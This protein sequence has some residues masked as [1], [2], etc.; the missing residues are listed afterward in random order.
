L[1]K[2]LSILDI[3]NSLN[4]SP[5]TVSFIVNGKAK[6]KRISDQLVEKVE[7]YIGEVGYTPNSLARSLR[8]GK[9]NIIGLMV[10]SISN[11]FFASIARLI[12]TKAYNNGYKI[13]YASTD[14]D[15]RKTRELIRMFRDRHVDGYIISPPE[16]IEEE[17]TSLVKAGV[18]VVF[19][20]RYIPGL[21]VDS[22]TID[23]F[24]STY[25]AVSDLIRQGRKHIGFITLDSLQTQMQDRLSGYEK[26]IE[27]HGLNMH[28]K[29]INFYQRSENITSHITSFFRKEK[30]LDAILF[31]TN[32]LGV[33]GL[34]TMRRLGIRIPEEIAVIAFDDHEIFDLHQPSIT[35]ISQPV[36]EI[37]DSIINLLLDKLKAGVKQRPEQKVV[38]P[39]SMVPR[40]SSKG[41]K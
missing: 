32:Y 35:A 37:A 5:T 9:S 24:T 27:E 22:V 2:K 16:G 19:F 29:E 15:T 38:L 21:E 8:T 13:I 36:E 10:E 11:P 7:K 6:E 33:S 17:I 14:N 25:N 18:P 26:A 34:K 30:E 41:K 1:K 20:D 3:A 12:E 4:I 28:I 39:A 40:D 31:S 23:N